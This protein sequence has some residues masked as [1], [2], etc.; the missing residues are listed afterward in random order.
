MV[1][2]LFTAVLIL[3]LVL[4]DQLERRARR[5]PSSSV[6]PEPPRWTP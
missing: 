3:F 2:V 6:H 5:F 4:A 1:P